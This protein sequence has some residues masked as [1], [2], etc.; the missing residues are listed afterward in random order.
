MPNELQKN[1]DT[2][3]IEQKESEILQPGVKRILWG[4]GGLLALLL[5]FTFA[6]PAGRILFFTGGLLSLVTLVIIALQSLIYS[7][8]WKAMAEGL[9]IE[10]AKTDP[11]L[12]VVGVTAEKFKVGERPIYIVTIAN[13]GLLP[14]TDVRTHMSIE[15]NDERPMDWID[16]VVTTIP[17]N[18]KEHYFIHSSFWLSQEQ[19][20]S[21]DSG[22]AL[23]RVVGFFK[24]APIGSTDFCYKYLS[25][26]GEDRPA[27]IP[28]F[29]RCDYAPRLNTTLIAQPGHHTLTGHAVIMTHGVVVPKAKNEEEKEQDGKDEGQNPN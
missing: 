25:M 3:Q 28:Q 5:V 20:D 18:G 12:R 21:F 6:L 14:A 26:Q 22:K 27:R 13:D 4:G 8:Q 17:A 24:Y 19:L 16:D 29:V 15:I 23:L 9:A 10:R 11:R 2:E 1:P 7:G